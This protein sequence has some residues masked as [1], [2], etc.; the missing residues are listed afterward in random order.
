MAHYGMQ[1]TV[2]GSFEDVKASVVKALKAQG[3]GVLTEINVQQTLKEKIGVDFEPYLILGACNPRLAH[4]ALSAD[5][6]IGLLLPCNVTLRS[7]GGDE[8]EVSILDPEVMFGVTDP[9][10]K[11]TLATLP[12]EAKTRLQ[13]A[14]AALKN[15]S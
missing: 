15:T 13:A 7:L 1:I 5:R 6:S 12:Q 2:K 11:T 10:T 8:V 3:F 4:Q 14:L 9:E